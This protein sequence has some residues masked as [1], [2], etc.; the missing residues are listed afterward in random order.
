MLAARMDK[1]AGLGG[2][3]F[4]RSPGRGR[5]RFA[6]FLFLLASGLFGFL[7]RCL[8]APTPPL[9]LRLTFRIL[10]KSF[11]LKL[12]GIFQFDLSCLKHLFLLDPLAIEGSPFDIFGFGNTQGLHH[13]GIFM[14]FGLGELMRIMRLQELDW[15][16]FFAF[17]ES[18]D[19]LSPQFVDLDG[20]I[21]LS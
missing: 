2:N 1:G 17:L 8:L 21:I 9:R 11:L 5:G 10:E 3:S 15:L 4:Y 7:F 14:L 16:G 6:A 12:S 13:L 19:Q 18:E 20:D